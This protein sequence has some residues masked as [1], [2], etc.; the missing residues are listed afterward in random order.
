MDKDTKI[1]VTNNTRMWIE[2]ADELESLWGHI[3]DALDAYDGS[4]VQE[5]LDEDFVP[6]LLGISNSLEKWFG[7]SA[8]EQMTLKNIKDN[9][10]RI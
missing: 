10:I 4:S 9:T 6:H 8:F 5:H 2:L 1:E 3:G 7:R